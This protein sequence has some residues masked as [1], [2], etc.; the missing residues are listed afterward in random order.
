MQMELRW[1]VVAKT[2]TQQQLIKNKAPKF[3]TMLGSKINTPDF[4]VVDSNGN[5]VA[6]D[7]LLG[8]LINDGGTVCDD[9]FTDNSAD[10]IC[11]KMGF[12]NGHTSW[13]YGNNW[14]IQSNYEITLADVVCDRVYW[15][16]CRYSLSHNCGHG[17]D[18]F[19][20]CRGPGMFTIVT[21]H[22]KRF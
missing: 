18:V 20:Q 8:L 9:G 10:A 2:S 17:E 15:S 19:L 1:S 22:P 6:A 16:E 21:F 14:S 4:S 11:R 3:H 7:R 5:T 13:S 12:P